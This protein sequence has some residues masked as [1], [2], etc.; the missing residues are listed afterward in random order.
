MLKIASGPNI[1]EL[2]GC[3]TKDKNFYFVFEF[4]KTTLDSY[5]RYKKY[6]E[7]KEGMFF[8]LSM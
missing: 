7:D 2:F 6:L 5:V 1:V 4:C 8:I 3:F